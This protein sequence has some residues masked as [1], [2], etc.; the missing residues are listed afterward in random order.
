MGNKD[1][2]TVIP[3]NL[4]YTSDGW[5]FVVKEHGL[6]SATI[7]KANA[8]GSLLRIQHN[9]L[10]FTLISQL[11]KG[12][13]CGTIITKPGDVFTCTGFSDTTAAVMKMLRFGTIL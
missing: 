10:S 7:Y 13:M 2:E 4:E 3:D 5:K 6:V 12:Y 1:E 11:D 9:G 8:G